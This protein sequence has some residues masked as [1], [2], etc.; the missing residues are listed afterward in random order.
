M[1]LLL[2][3]MLKRQNTI[4]VGGFSGFIRVDAFALL[5]SILQ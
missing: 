5:G 3:I 1:L 4:V 2:N